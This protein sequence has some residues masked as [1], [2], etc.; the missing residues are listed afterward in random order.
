MG[1]FTFTFGNKKIR[2]TGYGY[3]N[4]CK[5]LHGGIG[6]I[7][8]PKGFTSLYKGNDI[9][10]TN[11]GYT[12][13]AEH[14]YDSYGHFGSHDIYD[15]IVDINKG[16]LAESLEK[17]FNQKIEKIKTNEYNQSEEKLNDWIE[18]ETKEY[19]I[20]R[21]ICK[22]A[23]NDSDEAKISEKFK[24]LYNPFNNE[25]KRMLG[26]QLACNEEDNKLLYYPLKITSEIGKW[27]YDNLKP[28]ISTQ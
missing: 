5:L 26:I 27:N 10:T 3:S 14:Y 6:F 21:E 23:D 4:S 17:I 24:E 9:I 18:R 12:F 20:Y 13:I 8:L 22:M 11:D 2:E 19:N 16:H 28:T 7:A 15:V 25:W 1:C